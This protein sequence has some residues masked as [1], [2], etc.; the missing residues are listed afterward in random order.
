MNIVQLLLMLV[1]DVVYN[2][3]AKIKSVKSHTCIPALYGY[4]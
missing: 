1:V 4:D 2:S 3:F